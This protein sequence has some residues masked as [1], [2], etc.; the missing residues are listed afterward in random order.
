MDDDP[1]KSPDGDEKA[2][3]VLDEEIPPVLVA[4]VF[5]AGYP[6]LCLLTGQKVSLAVASFFLL[7]FGLTV[8]R[9]FR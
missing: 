3:S 4:L 9:T 6:C 1:T 5:T 7:I 8:Y 2:P